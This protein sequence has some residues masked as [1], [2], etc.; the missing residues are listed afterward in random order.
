MKTYYTFLIPFL[1]GSGVIELR[2][3]DFKSGIKN[4]VISQF[5][6]QEDSSK[7]LAK[8]NQIVISNLESSINFETLYKQLVEEIISSPAGAIIVMMGGESALEPLKH[9]SYERLKS[10]L[11]NFQVQT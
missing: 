6:N 11:T 8:V 3:K 10:L 7:F 9:Q 4:L 1:Y 5:F 2:F